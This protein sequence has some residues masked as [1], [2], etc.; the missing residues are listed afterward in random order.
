MRGSA[1]GVADESSLLTCY[2][3]S[4]DNIPE[5]LLPQ[6]QPSFPFNFILLFTLLAHMSVLTLIIFYTHT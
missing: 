1:S 4:T 3:T 2:A 6:L 5:D